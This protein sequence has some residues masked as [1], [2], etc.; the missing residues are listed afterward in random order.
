MK[1]DKI[2]NYTI[3]NHLVPIQNSLQFPWTAATAITSLTMP[4]STKT[5]YFTL[6]TLPLLKFHVMP[7]SNTMWAANVAL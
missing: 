3:G 4:A 2:N 1:R 7:K 5:Q 6:F